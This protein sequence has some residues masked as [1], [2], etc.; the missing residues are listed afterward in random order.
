MVCASDSV[1]PR[2]RVVVRALIRELTAGM[3]FHA[4]KTKGVFSGTKKVKGLSTGSVGAG[5]LVNVNVCGQFTFIPVLLCLPQDRP[6]LIR[7]RVWGVRSGMDEPTWRR[8]VPFG[9]LL[10]SSQH[11]SFP[12][13]HIHL[14]GKP[15][16]GAL[17]QTSL[18]NR[19]R[20]VF[21]WTLYKQLKCS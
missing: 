4:V 15:G 10:S 20:R 9:C 21:N 19:A 18:P 16:D 13:A 8:G 14:V 12:G 2:Q 3:L 1:P 17:L 7:G 5:G 11:P 6:M